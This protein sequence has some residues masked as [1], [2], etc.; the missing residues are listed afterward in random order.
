MKKL[1]SICFALMLLACAAGAANAGTIGNGY[2]GDTEAQARLD[3]LGIG[4]G[5]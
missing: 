2:P 4:A 1:V 3:A 5:A